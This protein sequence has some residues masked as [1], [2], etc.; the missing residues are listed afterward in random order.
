MP[1]WS[2]DRIKIHEGEVV[3]G[4]I[5]AEQTS[6]GMPERWRRRFGQQAL[7]YEAVAYRLLRTS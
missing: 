4:G 1:I 3:E 5:Q 2:I 7:R 6:T